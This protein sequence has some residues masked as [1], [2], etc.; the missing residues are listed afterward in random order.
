MFDLALFQHAIAACQLPHGKHP[1]IQDALAFQWADPEGSPL[2]G[3]RTRR[4]LGG[5]GEG[6]KLSCLIF[7]H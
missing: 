6:S 4:L 1:T 7:N 3:R 2:A 5:G